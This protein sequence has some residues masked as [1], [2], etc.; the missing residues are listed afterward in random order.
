MKVKVTTKSF[1]R[2]PE[3]VEALRADFPDCEFRQVARGELDR[4]G[5]VDFLHDAE[6][7]IVGLDP[8]DD[9]V[10]DRLPSLKVVCKYGVGLDNIDVGACLKRGV[11]VGWTAGVNRRSVAELTLGAM[12][13]L[14]RNIHVTSFALAGGQWNKQGGVQLTGR[15]VGL[16]GL[17][18]IG[19]DVASLLAP[20]SCRLLVHDILDKR[21]ACAAVGAHQVPFQRVLEESDVVSI[22]APLT[23]LTHHLFNAVTLS[24]MKPQAILINTARGSIVHQGALKEA[25]KSGRLAGAALDVFDPEPPSDAEFLALPTLISTPHIGGNAREAVIAMGLSAIKH[26]KAFSLGEKQPGLPGFPG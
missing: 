24:A 7:V 23:D 4:Q 13:G 1:S 17:G 16:I 18:H 3:L 19:S 26:L 25:L 11:Y 8:I 12:L 21:A 20:F 9:W 6:A 22:H 5:V 2:T 10:L 15:T 14:L